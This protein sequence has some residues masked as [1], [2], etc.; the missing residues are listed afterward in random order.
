M[1]TP[2][3]L[4]VLVVEDEMVIAFFIEDCL[5]ALGHRVAGPVSR[6]SKAL[7]LVETDSVDLALLDINVAGE[8]VYPVANELKLRAIPYVFLSGYGRRGL[9]AE[10]VDSPVLAK[11]F[12]AA[13]LEATIGTAM[14]GAA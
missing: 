2:K 13:A 4:N 7:R 8:E 14:H 9:R 10:W 5:K 6:V 12:A 11:P 3:P 1:K